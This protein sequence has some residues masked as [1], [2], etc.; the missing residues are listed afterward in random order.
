MFLIKKQIY[1]KDNEHHKNNESCLFF[2]EN[3]GFSNE[4]LKTTRV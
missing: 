3:Q 4:I 2:N 1:K